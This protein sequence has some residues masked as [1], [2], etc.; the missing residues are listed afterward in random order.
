MVL[1]VLV[2]AGVLYALTTGVP[3]VDDLRSWVTAAGWAGPVLYALL[4]AALT[5]T[6]VPASL[7]G[8]AG[9]VLFGLPVGLAVVLSG[10]MAGAVAGFV[11]ARHLGRGAVLW[12]GGRR[13][14]RLDDLLRRRG[15]PAVL[16]ARLVPLVPFTTLNVACGLTAVGR[17]DYVV[18]TAVGIL[19]ATTAYVT[20]GTYGTNPGSTPF[21]VAVGGLVVLAA[22]GVLAARRRV[23]TRRTTD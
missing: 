11:G 7:L 10:A 21:L 14:A 6:P 22:C 13:L 19:P 17:R 2:T 5:L 12:L 8:V 16:A 1:V 4:Y 3:Q 18:G 20:I 9:G 23:S 15:L